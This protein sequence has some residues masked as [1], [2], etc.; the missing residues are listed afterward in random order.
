MNRGG[1]RTR[2]LAAAAASI[3]IALVLAGLVLTFLFERHVQ[4]RLDME[5]DALVRRLAAGLEFSAEGRPMM[6]PPLAEAHFSTPFSGYYWQIDAVPGGAVLRAR[7]LWDRRLT[8]PDADIAPGGM[9]RMT[10]PGPDGGQVI[11]ASLRVV[12]QVSGQERRFDL[13]AA[14]DRAQLTDARNA[15]AWDLA[16]ALAVLAVFFLIAAWIQ[17]TVGLRPLAA[18]TRRLTELRAGHTTRLGGVHPAEVTP[19]VSE[20]NLLLDARDAEIA[21]ARSRAGDL[22]HGLKTPLAVLA[23][24]AWELRR[25]GV[26]A[27]ARSIDTQAELMTR[28]VERELARSRSQAARARPDLACDLVPVAHRLIATMARLPQGATLDWRLEAPDRLMARI[29]GDDFAELIGNLLDNARK[30]SAAE[31][32]LRLRPEAGQIEVCID[33]DGPGIPPER[34]GDARRRGNR[35]DRAVQGSGLGLAIV[36]DILEVY[37]QYL[38]LENR[39]EGG[40]RAHFTLQA[41]ETAGIGAPPQDNRR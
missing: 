22:A 27:V 23:A 28:H 5:L 10:L 34:L 29:D 13:I 6:V 18:L 3:L 9:R 20:I 35:L 33:D 16:Q 19:L 24:E 15:F 17:V 11:A 32:V 12:R 2:L 36:E 41:A 38:T 14:L 30:W 21:R 31:V 39:P 40:L 25:V 8:L 26:D 4:R 37:E 7:A 1:L